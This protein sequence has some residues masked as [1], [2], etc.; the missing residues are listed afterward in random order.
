MRIYIG[1]KD[2]KLS[3]S[4]LKSIPPKDKNNN[5]KSGIKLNKRLIKFLLNET[6]YFSLIIASEVITFIKYN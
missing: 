5:I 3:F 1:L 6:I 4:K 2:K